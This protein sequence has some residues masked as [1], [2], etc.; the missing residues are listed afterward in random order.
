MNPLTRV[1]GKFILAKNLR[2]LQLAFFLGVRCWRVVIGEES[3][4]EGEIRRACVFALSVPCPCTSRLLHVIFTGLLTVPILL[5]SG[6]MSALQGGFL[7][8]HW[9]QH[10]VHPQNTTHISGWSYVS[11]SC[12]A[13]QPESSVGMG[14]ACPASTFSRIGPGAKT[15]W[16]NEWLNIAGYDLVYVDVENNLETKN[17]IECK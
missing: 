13:H 8:P 17:S 1:C 4:S 9:G 14:P 12:C 7:T 11:D 10:P 16:M 6:W 15:W 2:F 5:L 3:V